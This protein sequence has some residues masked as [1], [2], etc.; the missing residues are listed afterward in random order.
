M[1]GL[2]EQRMEEVEEQLL[3]LGA[4]L[5]RDDAEGALDQRANDVRRALVQLQAR[6]HHPNRALQFNQ[7]DDDE[8]YTGL[9]ELDGNIPERS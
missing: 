5:V 1:L 7:K 2:V 8:V 3:D 4:R 6:L 9:E